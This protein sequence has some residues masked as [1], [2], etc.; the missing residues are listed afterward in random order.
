MSPPCHPPVPHL[1]PS[2]SSRSPICPLSPPQRCHLLVTLQVLRLSPVTF[3]MD[4]TSCHLLVTLLSPVCHPPGPPTV[5]CHL[6]MDVTSLSLSCPSFVTFQVLQLSLVTSPWMSPPCH[7]LVP[8]LSP[9][10]SSRSFNCPLSPFLWMPPPVTS[11]SPSCPQSV[12]CH[13]PRDVTS[14]SPSRSSDCPLSLSP[15]MSPPC[16]PLVP[17]LSPSRSSRSSDCPLSPPF[18]M[19][20][21]ATSLSPSCPPSVTL[22]VPCLSPVTSS[23]D[24][25]SLSPTCRPPG[26]PV[27]PCHLL[28]GCPLLC[29][30]LVTLQVLRLSPVTSPMDVTSCHLLVTLQVPRLSPVTS[31]E[32]SPPCR[33]PCPPTVPCHLLYRCHLCVT[34]CS[35]R[36]PQLFPV[37][38]P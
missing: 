15:W 16:H 35:F 27:G 12:P 25:P 3:P 32:M 20:P 5:P 17:H 38:S 26:L 10:R 33:P 21:P 34:P 22:R 11:L 13:L 8:H 31:P 2:R 36:F 29:H 37:T 14:L 18:W 23:M 4:V 24:V 30:L 6:P 1:S 28:Y 9:S 19:S 7:P